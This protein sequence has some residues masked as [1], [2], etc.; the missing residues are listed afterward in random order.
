M[1][2]EDR[3]TNCL[4]CGMPRGRC[5]QFGGRR[6][7]GRVGAGARAV[8]QSCR[9]RGADHRELEGAVN[10]RVDE[11]ALDG[12]N[13][14]NRPTVNSRSRDDNRGRVGGSGDN[15]LR[16]RVEV[17][18]VRDGNHRAD[19]WRCAAVVYDAIQCAR[20]VENGCVVGG[21]M[22]TLSF[23]SDLSITHS[24]ECVDKFC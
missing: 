23:L 6:S 15:L 18:D 7:R 3:A 4:E 20:G 16:G 21:D 5:V 17:V 13:I 8:K 2:I 12:D 22:N 19:Q 10:A 14:A 11:P 9:G 24:R 1:I